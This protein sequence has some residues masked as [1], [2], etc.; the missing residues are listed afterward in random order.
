MVG[1][2]QGEEEALDRHILE[3]EAA[4][5]EALCSNVNAAGALQALSALM[6]RVNVYLSARPRPQGGPGGAPFPSP[7]PC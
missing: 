1:C 7:S 3:A 6:S 4:V 5:H 2:A